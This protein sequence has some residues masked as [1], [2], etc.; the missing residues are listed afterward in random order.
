MTFYLI[1]MVSTLKFFY[2][3]FWVLYTMKISCQLI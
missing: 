3:L 1:I 2:S